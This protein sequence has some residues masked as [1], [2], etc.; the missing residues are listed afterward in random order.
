MSKKDYT[1]SVFITDN[2]IGVY[3]HNEKN[4]KK[5]KF[6]DE[7]LPLGVIEYGY[8]KEPRKFLTHIKKVFKKLNF[9]PSRINWIIQ[10][11]NILI[12][13]LNV[14]KSSLKDNDIL[15]YLESQVNITLF[16]PFG[17]ATFAYK[18]KSE[19]EEEI[20]LSVFIADKNL[21][22][23]YLDIFDTVKIK[24]TD[25]NI[26]SS[27]ISTLYSDKNTDPLE[28]SMVVTIYDN[29]L[30]IN[31]IESKFTIF[32]MNDECDLSS[33]NATS[34]I[35]EYVER[36][37]NYY[38]FNLRKGKQSINNVFFVDLS[39]S[40][41]KLARIKKFEK[42]N[43]L[44]Y[45]LV[46]LKVEDLNSQL[47]DSPAT[48]DISYI[49]SIISKKECFSDLDFN[50]IRPNKT[51]VHLNYIMLFSISLIMI[52][53]LIYIPYVNLN[54]Q[55]L[56][57]QAINNGLIIQG[58][59]LEQSVENNNTFSSY[60]K[61]YNQVFTYLNLQSE[62]ETEYIMDLIDLA[63]TEI[64]LTKFTFSS[65][66]KKIELSIS[67]DSQTLLYEY[68]ISVY[69]EFGV[70][71]GVTNSDKWI[72]SYPAATFTSEFTMRVVIYYA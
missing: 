36:I 70:L 7:A 63:G 55:I 57:Q 61:N 10:D 67:G 3:T 49:T 24:I 29:N 37:A 33:S 48:V 13:E 23:D 15:S 53:S 68:V 22:D 34:I 41:D 35:E 26:I 19:D 4:E 21:I 66:D 46:F 16:F 50:I 47:T 40:T 32:G 58:N 64:T 51:I 52:I 39:E 6:A 5:T 65:Q 9:K 20:V 17:E 71:N 18:V 45:N 28:N 25:F 30:T 38:Q 59:M 60:E 43:L 14:K 31:I 72:V 69:E 54:D 11:Q 62:K 2:N 27:V 1:T 42:E 8:I 12:R 44:N 56:E